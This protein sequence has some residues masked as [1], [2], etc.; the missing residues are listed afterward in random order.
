MKYFTYKLDLIMLNI[1]ACVSIVVLTILTYIFT[2]SLDFI[3]EINL[4][5]FLMVFLWLGLHEVLHGVG[6]L[7]LGRV[8]LRNIVFG[9]ELE[10]GIFY[11]MCKEVISKLNI[12]IAIFFPFVLIGIIPYIIGISNSNNLLIFLA[13]FNMAGSIADIIMGINIL[14]MPNDIKYLDLDDN[15][16]FTI[17][18][19]KSLNKKKYFLIILDKFGKY[20]DNIKAK[21][22]KKIT[23]SKG[24]KYVFVV[25]I[26][27]FIVSVFFC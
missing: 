20:N 11:C 25:F 18:S 19:K 26:L 9:A 12:L 8:K 1:F 14:V 23:I 6:F 10:K 27:L 17:L 2:G 4:F 3:T 24:S 5:S 16:G 15:T 7:S 22:Y 13:V 21:D